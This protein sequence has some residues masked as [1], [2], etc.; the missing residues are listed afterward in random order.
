MSRDELRPIEPYLAD[1]SVSELMWNGYDCAFAERDGVIV[2]V[3]SPFQDESDFERL[4]DHLSGLK[5]TVN[6]NGLH[7]DG[8]LSDGSRFHVT[9]PPMSPGG[10][11]LTIRKFSSAFRGLEKLAA[12][13]F[14][15]EKARTF[16][17]GCVQA[18]LNI[19]ISGSTGAG[20]STLLNALASRVDPRER[21]I[22]IEDIPEIQ[23]NHPNWV[24]LVSVHQVPEVS[25]RDCLIGS[26]RMRPD[27]ILIGECR[28]S[29]TLDMLQALNTGHDGGMTTLHANSTGDALTRMESLILF[30]AGAEIPLRAL[31]K[32]IVDALDLVVQVK[33]SPEGTRYVDEI[34]EVTGLEGD[35]ITRLPLFKRTGAKGQ[36]QLVPTGH[37][38]TFLKRL[39]ERGVNLPRGFFA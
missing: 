24:R 13:G 18:R 26:L 25:V 31:R 38:P 32:Q 16:L 11:T 14:I 1:A 7:F 36:T 2:Q 21:I 8:I 39:E 9:R 12:S 28:S 19:V 37:P 3:T 15:S 23:L 34:I 17:E 30:H 22:T 4:V 29:E 6:A 35:V 27:R 33:K 10:P 20:K 5:N